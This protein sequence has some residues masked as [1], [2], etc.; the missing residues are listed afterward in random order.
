[1]KN[2]F[3][4]VME[5]CK[6]HIKRLIIGISISLLTVA[7]AVGVLGG[8]VYSKA[9]G[10]IKYSQDKL[11]QIA[12]GKVQGE[13]IK[14]EKELNFEEAVYEYE[15]RIKDKENMLQIVKVDSQNGVILR[16]NNEKS[17]NENE[18]SHRDNNGDHGED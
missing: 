1:M 15:F 14:I 6:T 5:Y 3:V 2:I 16:V 17:R 9:K 13:V 4:W 11:Q 18:E 8:V 12:L 7:I 10:N